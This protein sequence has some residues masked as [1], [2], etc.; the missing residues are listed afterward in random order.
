MKKLIVA[1]VAA[2]TLTGSPLAALA[3]QASGTI[4]SIDLQ[5]GALI[6]SDGKVYFMPPIVAST[7]SSLTV[8][9]KVTVTSNNDPNGTMQVSDVQPEA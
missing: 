9:E 2:I 6:L 3:D 1:A 5:G 8:G 4:T 7:A